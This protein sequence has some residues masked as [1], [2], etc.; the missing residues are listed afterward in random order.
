MPWQGTPSQD[1]NG[2]SLHRAPVS[3]RETWEACECCHRE[4]TCLHL[5]T[6][7]SPVSVSGVV[8]IILSLAGLEQ[9]A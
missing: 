3:P 1:V 5:Y 4:P 6:C 8:I 9:V 2:A 7:S